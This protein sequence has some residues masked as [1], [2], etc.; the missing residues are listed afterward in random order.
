MTDPTAHI[1]RYQVQHSAQRY[2]AVAIVLHWAIA[3]AIVGNIALGWWMHG[4]I[5]IPET[6]ARA[7]AAFQLHKSIGLT[8]LALSLFRLVWRLIH[9]PP[10]LPAGMP[11]W[12]KF[13]AKA[14]HWIFYALMIGIPICG[15]LYVST[16]WRGNAPLNIPTLWFGRF[17]IPH[18]FGLND[19]TRQWREALAGV[20]LDAHEF[21][22]WSAAALLVLHV[23]AALKHH[24]VN[25]DAVLGHMIPVLQAMDEAAPVPQDRRRTAIL[26]GG[27]AAIA[28]AATAIGI[29]L[30]R[31]P[32]AGGSSE[33]VTSTQSAAALGEHDTGSAITSAEGGWVID[34]AR[35]EI[36]FSGVHAGV[37]FRG[38]FT[39]WSADIR[40]DLA[41]VAQSH[42]AAT[43]Q[44]GSATDGVPLHDETLPQAEW[45]DVENHPVAT[46]RTTRIQ[47]E[48]DRYDV[49]GTLT[50]KSHDMALSPLT[51]T[52][53][54]DRVTISGRVTID[55]RDADMGME[56]DP[57]AAWVSREI[58]ID[59]RVTS[60]AMEVPTSNTLL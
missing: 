24:L 6:Q 22:A 13:A 40:L 11:V 49:E 8:I 27:F 3:A 17:E 54:G 41:D 35:S 14:T 60:V 30:V 47:Q 2:T 59:V 43:I 36:A 58:V 25:R 10:P 19:A 45:F 46:F 7:I 28:V 51:L 52:I 57:D 50:I 16:Q 4:A 39:R 55:R 18:L 34:P 32:G 12:E 33:E 15:W 9:Q 38:R 44:T 21:L 5:E 26:I 53:D 20:A 42:I 29:A 48:G 37:P 56:S 23:A 31:T 1:K